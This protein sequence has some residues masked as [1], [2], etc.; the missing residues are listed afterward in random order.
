MYGLS[1]IAGL[2]TVFIYLFTTNAAM[3][4]EQQA[5]AEATIYAGNM[6]AYGSY[7][8]RYA[9]SNPTYSGTVSDTTANL[10]NWLI[11]FPE[12]TNVVSTGTA[13]L[14]M[15]PPSEARGFAIAVAMGGGLHS[16]LKVSGRLQE[17]GAA[18]PSML[19][20]ANIPDG[21]VVLVL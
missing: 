20:P 17:P 12:I 2:L 4:A 1:L 8:A 5:E 15:V 7:V 11:R 14:Y 9:Y 18:S 6:T 10:P 19:L 21:A 16:G 3:M 13:Y